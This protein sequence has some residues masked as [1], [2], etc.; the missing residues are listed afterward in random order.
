MARA[1]YKPDDVVTHVIATFFANNPKTREAFKAAGFKTRK[2]MSDGCKSDE[3]LKRVKF[4]DGDDQK[5]AFLTED[6]VEELKLVESYFNWEQNQHGTLP[7]CILDIPAVTTR[8]RFDVFLSLD[9]HGRQGNAD[10]TVSYDF[11]QALASERLNKI[12]RYD[13]SV[14]SGGGPRLNTP[15]KCRSDAAE[16]L[17]NFEKKIK[18][19]G[20][21]WSPLETAA[22]WRAW[23]IKHEAHLVLTDMK[24][25]VDDNYTP[26][27]VT[28]GDDK[29]VVSLYEKK[30]TALFLSLF[31]N[32]E[33]TEGKIIVRKH[34]ATSDGVAAWKELVAHYE[35]DMSAVTRTQQLLE[36]II[37]SRIPKNHKGLAASIDTFK[38]W[39][40]EHNNYCEA[41]HSINADQQLIYLERFISSIEDLV[42]TKELM[43]IQE[44]TGIGAA[45]VQRTP[46]AKM[47]FYYQQ[48][49]FLDAKHKRSVLESR[50]ANMMD[51]GDEMDFYDHYDYDDC[52]RSVSMTTR[53]TVEAVDLWY[54]INATRA[55]RTGHILAKVWKTMSE[56][57]KRLWLDMSIEARET[58][59]THLLNEEDDRKP[60]PTT[61][62]DPRITGAPI[63]RGA[64][65]TNVAEVQE[66]PE[67]GNTTERVGTMSIIG[68]MRERTASRAES[69]N[70]N[71]N[72][73]PPFIPARLMSGQN[74]SSNELVPIL[75][76]PSNEGGNPTPRKVHMAVSST[77]NHANFPD[78]LDSA[79]RRSAFMA[80]A[81]LFDAMSDDD[82]VIH[83]AVTIRSN[84]ESYG[85]VDSG[86]N[87]GFA[88]PENLRLV[89]YA[90][91]TRYISIDGISGNDGTAVKIGTFAAKATLS[92]NT[93][94]ILMLHEFGVTSYG[95]TILSKI[96]LAHGGC[97]VNDMP[98]SLGGTQCIATPATTGPR[99]L[100]PLKIKDGL[101]YIKMTYPTEDDMSNLPRIALTKD[102]PWEPRQ[103]DHNPSMHL[104]LE[105]LGNIGLFRPIER[106]TEPLMSDTVYH[107]RIRMV[108]RLIRMEHGVEEF[109]DDAVIEGEAI[110]MYG[111][112]QTV[113]ALGRNRGA[114]VLVDRGANMGVMV[115][116]HR[117]VEHETVRDE[118]S[119][120]DGEGF[121]H[122]D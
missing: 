117:V 52:G 100:L 58:I 51:M 115:N 23:K 61:N 50:R 110:N 27:S 95:P 91:P 35:N 56:K 20:D 80:V 25:I 70:Q 99:R 119:E 69:S 108:N 44:R 39:I 29:E 112:N 36:L 75:K 40:D 18:L 62:E 114:N 105:H 7:A 34:S 13:P 77:L 97:I 84:S 86:A 14:S 76:E 120:T 15:A 33:T 82:Y 72:R 10:G 122:V 30:R 47:D 88:N 96:Q 87:N 45:P 11:D 102:S 93:E 67:S 16:A 38:K 78:L 55:R 46:Q 65:T 94:V 106:R 26:P 103:Y 43:Q 6:E 41:G 19:G 85:L 12:G 92:D 8:E 53:E 64:R 37:A 116:H 28:N 71:I 4:K 98:L 111:D 107:D 2:D 48:A 109:V 3:I 22:D 17:I 73:M 121:P 101:A 113:V 68:S 42:R 24:D 104:E 60:P 21:S 1:T 59:V 32:I 74:K 66:E 31:E 118:D 79:S 89:E 90:S 57:D 49:I 54:K 63:A 9:A 81:R 83:D 5:E